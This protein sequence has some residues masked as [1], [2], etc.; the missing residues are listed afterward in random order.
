MDNAG[1]RPLYVVLVRDS[2]QLPPISHGID[3]MRKYVTGGEFDYTAQVKSAFERL[4][5]KHRC[6]YVMLRTQYHMHPTICAIHS[7]IFYNGAIVNGLE[8][9]F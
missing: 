3:L 6:T 4:H 2:Q 5:D 7:Q 9:S 8:K 1:R